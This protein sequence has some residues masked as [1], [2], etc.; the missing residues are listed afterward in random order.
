MFRTLAGLYLAGLFMF[1]GFGI[2]AGC[3]ALYN[4]IAVTVK[5]VGS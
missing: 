5:A 1:R 2:A 3:H 4:V